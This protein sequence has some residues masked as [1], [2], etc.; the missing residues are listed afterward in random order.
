MLE[1]QGKLGFKEYFAII[2]LV[3]GTKLTDNTPPIF[4]HVLKNAAWISPII[5]GILV[6][7]PLY[8]LIKVISHYKEQNLLKAITH[9]FGKYIGTFVVFIMWVIASIAIVIDS[10]TYSDIIESMYYPNTPA[11]LIYGM[12]M[13]VCAY[14]AKR[15]IE[16][17]G[18][19]AWIFLPL[20]K[21]SF[22]IAII[23]TISHGQVNFLFPLLGPGTWTIIKESS[24]KLSIFMD[25]LYL[26]ILIPLIKNMKVFKKATWIGLI[27]IVI[28]IIVVFI[29]YTMLFDYNAS[30]MLGYPYHEIIRYIYIGFLT[31]MEMFFVP[32][33]LMA[34]FIRFAVYLYINAILFGHIFKIKNFE[35]IIPSIATII[36]FAGLIPD[37]RLYT[38]FH[39]RDLFI[40]ITTPIFFFLPCLLWILAKVKGVFNQ[41][42]KT[43]R[44]VVRNT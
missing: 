27:I 10:S 18:S 35:Y 40:N 11:L 32:L 43:S 31:N 7:I 28:E 25:V 24:L 23:L 29:S 21:I 6:A 4:F 41:D 14:G 3:I 19:V 5:Q 2:I 39:F 36:V 15:G 20:I 34:A 26:C 9:L 37:S 8:L 38:L 1:V 16:H 22:V 44:Q 13:F 30:E 33:W 42:E 12:L 17:I